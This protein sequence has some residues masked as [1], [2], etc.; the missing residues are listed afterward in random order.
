MIVGLCCAGGCSQLNDISRGEGEFRGRTFQGQRYELKT[1]VLP[2][3]R[4]NNTS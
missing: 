3:A 2:P 4:T 1:L